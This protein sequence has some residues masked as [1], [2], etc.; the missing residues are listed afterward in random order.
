MLQKVMQ[1]LKGDAILARDG[2][3]G[4]VDDVYFDDERW[5]VR[6]LVVDTGTWLAGRKVLISPA[7]LPPQES[8]GDYLRVDLTREQV[9]HAP[10]IGEDPP[11][12]RTL[13]EAHA[14]YYGYP[15]YWAGPYMWGI[16]AL[17]LGAW[18][19]DGAG[20]TN[21]S[22]EM[23][24]SALQRARE[25]HLRSSAAIV[26]YRI[27]AE[28]GELGHVADF[29]VD[30]RSWAI[31]EMIVDTRNWLPGKKVI[32]PTKAIADI[33]WNKG[34]LRVNLKRDEIK[35]APKSH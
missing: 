32:V 18:R 10:D 14:R 20:Q 31:T 19:T 27:R 35:R 16:A 8:G 21:E 28:D 9:E 25:S 2:R 3:I 17:P 7:S 23:L 11:I 30:D 1:D 12:S 22:H 13:E 5:A 33:D 29:L 4:S 15:Q 24:Q 34:E 6:Y 26:G